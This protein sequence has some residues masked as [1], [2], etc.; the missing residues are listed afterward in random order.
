MADLDAYP[1]FNQ[2]LDSSCGFLDDLVLDRA[3]NGAGRA[4]SFYTTK[5]RAFDLRHKLTP[6][7]FAQLVA[8]YDANK[9]FRVTLN[10]N[11]DGANYVCF[12]A[13]PPGKLEYETP[14]LVKVGVALVE[15]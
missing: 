8:F 15:Q 13:G 6:S 4:R 5:K 10:W 1:A 12:F 9:L 14:T 11:P 3:V 2:L 7:E